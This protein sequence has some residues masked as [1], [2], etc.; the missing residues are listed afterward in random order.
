M[1]KKMTLLLAIILLLGNL[2]SVSAETVDSGTFYGLQY[3]TT[4]YGITAYCAFGDGLTYPLNA[5][6][7]VTTSKSGCVVYAVST[8]YNEAGSGIGGNSGGGNNSINI[9][10]VPSTSA[11]MVK[12]VHSN[13]TNNLQKSYTLARYR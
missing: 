3:T 11:Y 8:A 5:P 2:C 10:Y 7:T 12:N 6:I 4:G 1:K 9:S 13:A